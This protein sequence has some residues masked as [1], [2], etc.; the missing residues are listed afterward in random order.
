MS[1]NWYDDA[2]NEDSIFEFQLSKSQCKWCIC[3]KCTKHESPPQRIPNDVRNIAIN[4]TN[5]PI[6]KEAIEKIS[7]EDGRLP[8][9]YTCIFEYEYNECGNC[10][11]GRCK[12]IEVG[13]VKLKYCYSEIDP[14]RSGRIPI[15]FHWDFKIKWN[16]NKDSNYNL[17]HNIEIFPYSNNKKQRIVKENRIN[18]NNVNDNINTNSYIKKNLKSDDEME[19]LLDENNYLWNVLK[20]S[21]SR[22]KELT[23]SLSNCLIKNKSEEDIK[24]MF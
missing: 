17:T 16:F 18:S 1:N 15:A 13:G 4:P 10:K 11:Q 23:K 21:V 9:V 19:K 6:I 12:E 14:K 5:V 20:N 2:I 3:K 22:D 8:H 24:H 7:F